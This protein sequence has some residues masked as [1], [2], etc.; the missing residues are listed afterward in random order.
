MEG[1]QLVKLNLFL[2]IF[3]GILYSIMTYLVLFSSKFNNF[4]YPY[5]KLQ[6]DIDVIGFISAPF[7]IFVIINFFILL[8]ILI[9]KYE[10]NSQ[11]VKA[12]KFNLIILIIHPIGTLFVSYYLATFGNSSNLDGLRAIPFIFL[13][14]LFLIISSIVISIIL[15]IG[16]LKERKRKTN[17]LY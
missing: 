1:K 10:I 15:I 9:K 8:Y 7:F 13:L 3:L 17:F 5:I 11:M 2:I 16:L 6:L 14:L 12:S 4:L